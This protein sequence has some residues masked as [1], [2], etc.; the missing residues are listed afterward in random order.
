ME[1]KMSN[2]S[3]LKKIIIAVIAMDGGEVEKLV[4]QAIDEQVDPNDVINKGLIRGMKDVGD[5]FIKK[6]YYVPEVLLAS[7]AFYAGF[8]II[9]PLVKSREIKKAKVVIGVVK[10]DIHDI[11]K[12]IVRVLVE[13]A[14]FHVIDLGKDV[15]VASFVNAVIKEKPNILAMSSLMTTTLLQMENVISTLKKK[16]LRNK[17]KVI[18]GGAPVT[19][20]YA[21]KIGADGYAEDAARAVQLFD[22]LANG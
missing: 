5:L 21:Q 9:A 18:I 4:Y 22:K 14:G 20:E 10:G 7:E 12:N 15:S 17:V 8:N 3:L 16:S 2:E 13:A 1:N 6:E 19:A 11:G